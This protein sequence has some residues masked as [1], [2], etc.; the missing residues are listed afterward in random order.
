MATLTTHVASITFVA[1]SRVH[2]QA[3]RPARPAKRRFARFLTLLM[4]ALGAVHC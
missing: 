2:M 3:A 4:R 1:A